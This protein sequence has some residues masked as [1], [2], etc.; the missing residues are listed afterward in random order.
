MRRK[1]WI[2]LGVVAAA[3]LLVLVVLPMFKPLNRL[4]CRLVDYD[5]AGGWTRDQRFLLGF[6]IQS[7]VEGNGLTD[8]YGRLG[9]SP[10]KPRWQLVH[11]RTT[12]EGGLKRP[13]WTLFSSGLVMLRALDSAKFTEPARRAVMTAYRRVC[14]RD[15][16]I[17]QT[18]AQA[19]AF[20]HRVFAV[21][22]AHR[23]QEVGPEML[24]L[25]PS[26]ASGPQSP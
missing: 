7:K 2:I 19:E 4:N 11:A 24:N 26:P 25:G 1:V 12:W 8:E 21:A 10:P 22:C 18:A 3:L 15:G 14:E 9:L 13:G 6:C 20:A 5:Y 17:E 16:S 23:G